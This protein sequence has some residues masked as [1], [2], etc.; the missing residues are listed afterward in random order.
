MC[1]QQLSTSK[2][3]ASL[4]S[5]ATINSK[6]FPSLRF[7]PVFH[8]LHVAVTE[9]HGAQAKRPAKITWRRVAVAGKSVEA[10]VFYRRGGYIGSAYTQDTER[11]SQA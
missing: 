11:R 4:L 5:Q 8:K 9:V 7:P 10:I 3:F 6:D 2:A 1:T